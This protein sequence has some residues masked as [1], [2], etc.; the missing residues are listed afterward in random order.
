MVYNTV[1]SV[2]KKVERWEVKDWISIRNFLFSYKFL[3]K[4][5]ILSSF[6]CSY[7]RSKCFFRK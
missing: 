2:F 5:L 6:G 7:L 4:I 3:S 1:M